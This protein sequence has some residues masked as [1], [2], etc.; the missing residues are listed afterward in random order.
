MDETTQ[1]NAAL[2]EQAAAAAESLQDQAAGLSQAVAVFRLDGGGG[3]IGSPIPGIAREKARSGRALPA[4]HKSLPGPS[5]PGDVD[6]DAIINAH[7]AWKQKLRSAIGG[8]EERKLNPNEV[9]KDNQCALGKWLYGAGKKYQH[10]PDYEPLRH[11]HAEFH[12][13]AADIL[14][15]TQQGDKDSA[16]A[17]LVGEF[18]DL[19]NRTVQ[20]IVAMKRHHRH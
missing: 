7:Q 9:C 2:V 15:L 10:T 4:A 18:F 20:H 17:M 5:H 6:F 19:S 1:Q 12:V 16:N 13:C 8:G 3:A 11:T 14:R